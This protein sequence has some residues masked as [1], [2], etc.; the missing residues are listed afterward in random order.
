MI[1][2]YKHEG[3]STQLVDR[4]DPAWIKPGSGICVWVDLDRPT[5][6]ETKVLSDTF[7]FHQLAIEDALSELHHPK[8]ESYGDYLY[9]IL[10]GIDFHASEHRFTTKDVDF[11]LGSQF[12]VTV[13]PGVSRSIGKVGVV[14]SRDSRMLGEGPGML[15]YRIVDTMVDNYRPEVDKLSEKLDKLE[16]EV[17]EHPNTQLARRILNFKKDISSLRQTVLPQRDVV[18]RLARREFPLITEQLA[19]GFRDVHDHLVRLSDEAMFFQDRITSILDAH[20]SAVSN[21]LNQVMK[22]LTIIATLFMPLT[23]LTGM[24]G[25]N[26][27]LP[28]LPGGEH[29]QFWWVCGI[30]LALSAAML[31][32]FRKKGWI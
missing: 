32:F 22:V 8:I 17:F 9:V 21:Q 25:M 10:H 16:K 6:D 19:Y 23:V 14:C 29:A 15:L 1:R 20:L 27:P 5:P 4:V 11:F 26:V 18:G 31:G 7:H 12:L 30:M 13:H 2:I 24:Y 3:G 28:H